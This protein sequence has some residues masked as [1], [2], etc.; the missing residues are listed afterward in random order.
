MLTY[1]PYTFKSLQL[2]KVKDIQEAVTRY[3]I[4]DYGYIKGTEKLKI[5]KFDIDGVE[6]TP[7]I[8]YGLS[9]LER[10]IP[11]FYQ[12]IVNLKEKWIAMDLRQMVNANK[13]DLSVTIRN[14]PEYI[15]AVQKL[16]LT[17]L[18]MGGNTSG[19]YSFKLP[20]AVFSNWLSET[21]SRKFGLDPGTQV[22]LKALAYVYY[23]KLFS[24]EWDVDDQSKLLI[25]SKDEFFI[26]EA[27]SEILNSEIPLNNIDDFAQ[28]C[29]K[30][31]GNIRLEGLDYNVLSNIVSNSWFGLNARENVLLALQYPPVWVSMVY[32]SLKSKTFKKSYIAT[33]VE[34]SNKR[35]SGDEFIKGLSEY[36]RN[37][38][39]KE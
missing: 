2:T 16:V 12:P 3:I 38:I 9:D 18:W 32:A 10:E 34:K 28:A 7:V 30:F 15:M 29:F 36:T 35:G 6:V 25:R 13:A 17:G 8:L 22:K 19:L 27:I 24:D 23:A 39:V 20:H 37:H 5:N 1:N 33:L 31:T 4:N 26:Q 11:S 21:I 14:E